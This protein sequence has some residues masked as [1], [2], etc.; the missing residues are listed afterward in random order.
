[1]IRNTGDIHLDDWNHF[2]T[3]DDTATIYHTPEWKSFLESTFDYKSHYLFAQNDSGEITGLLP[4]YL[5]KDP[6]GSSRLCS[7]PFAHD[8]GPIGKKEVRDQLIFA[9]IDLCK[10]LRLKNVEIRDSVLTEQLNEVNSFSTYVLPLSRDIP[11]VWKRLDKGSVRWAITKAKK[12]GVSVEVTRR[13]E[14]LKQFYELN[15]ITKKA[16]GVPCHPWEFFDNLFI[17]LGDKVSLYTA[18]YDSQIIGGGIM[19]RFKDSLLYGYGAANPDYLN[20]HPYNA[21]IWRSI[22]DAC[23]TG[24]KIYDFGRTSYENTGLIQ[25]KKKWGTEEKKLYYSY[26]PPKSGLT[27]INRSSFLFRIATQGFQMMPMSLYKSISGK[28]F[29]RFG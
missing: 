10:N 25:F 1:M 28:I 21:F 23:T 3:Y 2:L 15:C 27:P 14:D 24:C 11:D 13:R 12:S 8:C 22:E 19:I 18:G 6:F 9:A 29:E 17:H 7:T 20:L 5:I 4:L 26:Y 16:L